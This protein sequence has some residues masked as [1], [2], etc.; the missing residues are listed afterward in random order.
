MHAGHPLHGRT[1]ITE[2]NLGQTCRALFLC[3]RAMPRGPKLRSDRFY[4]SD[5]P[6]LKMPVRDL[7]T[8]P[9]SLMLFFCLFVSYRL[10]LMIM[11]AYGV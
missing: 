4:T 2:T 6:K 11:T 10:L 9:K 7:L 3:C 8:P 5:F 1:C